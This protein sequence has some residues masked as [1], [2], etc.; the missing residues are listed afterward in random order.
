MEEADEAV[1]RLVHDAV[2]I[3]LRS[4]VPDGVFLSGGIDSSLVAAIAARERR[5]R[6]KTFTMTFEEKDFDES[7]HAAE[8]ARRLGTEHHAFLG[9]RAMLELL[10]EY[11][12]H[13]G[14]PFGDSSAFNVWRLSE[15]TRRHVT[16]ALGGD[17]GDEAFAGYDWYRTAL[18]LRRIAAGL[19]TPLLRGLHATIGMLGSITSAPGLARVARGLGHLSCAGDAERFASLRTFIGDEEVAHLYGPVLKELRGGRVS[20]AAMLLVR[21]FEGAGGSLLR[22]LRYTDIRTYLADCLMPKVDVAAMAHG[23]EVRAPLLDHRIIEL[24]LDLPDEWLLDR[25]RGKLMMRRLVGR[26]LP[27]GLFDRHKQGFSIPLKHWFKGPPTPQLDIVGCAAL[28]DSGLI[29]REGVARLLRSHALGH[30]DHSQR[31]FNLLVLGRW[32]EAIP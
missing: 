11:L 23:L 22:R 21:Q 32:L 20:P 1:D 26:Y 6:V 25:S 3:R 4:D 9:S 15:G 19:P 16:V 14:E 12:R 29:R 18:R 10:P 13:F 5:D 17:G 30:R 2:R 8:V 28:F 31:L 7:A 24:A 27:P